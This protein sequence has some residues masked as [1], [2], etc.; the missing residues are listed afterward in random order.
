MRYVDF[1]IMA[2]LL[3]GANV[4][5]ELAILSLLRSSLWVYSAAPAMFIVCT[6][7]NVT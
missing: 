1:G 7:P 3:A 2:R 6:W 5:H 4:I